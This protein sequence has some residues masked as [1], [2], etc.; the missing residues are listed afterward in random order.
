MSL[1]MRAH[2]RGA[3]RD[4]LLEPREELALFLNYCLFLLQ[5]STAEAVTLLAGPLAL[6]RAVTA[7]FQTQQTAFDLARKAAG[8]GDLRAFDVA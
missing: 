5:C 2:R 3:R 4:S 7:L 6:R 8:A 1:L